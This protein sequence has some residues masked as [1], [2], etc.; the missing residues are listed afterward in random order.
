MPGVVR[1]FLL[2]LDDAKV[3]SR[4]HT[5]AVGLV[6]RKTTKPR[7]TPAWQ[8][9]W[10]LDSAGT[11]FLTPKVEAAYERA[12]VSS[13]DTSDTKWIPKQWTN[14][15]VKFPS[16]AEKAR[17]REEKEVLRWWMVHMMEKHAMFPP[18]RCWAGYHSHDDRCALVSISACPW[19][20]FAF[21]VSPVCGGAL[22]HAKTPE[23]PCPG[24]KK[25]AHGTGAY[26]AIVHHTKGH[27]TRRVDN[28]VD[29]LAR[30]MKYMYVD[31]S[32]IPMIQSGIA[33][34]KRN[35]RKS[36]HPND[37]SQD[38]WLASLDR[39][40]EDNNR[41]IDAH[42]PSAPPMPPTP[43]PPLH[44]TGQAKKQTRR[45]QITHAQLKEKATRLRKELK[46]KLEKGAFKDVAYV[47]YADPDKIKN[48]LK[49]CEYAT[50]DIIQMT[51][52]HTKTDIITL[53][54]LRDGAMPQLN[55]Q[56]Y[57]AS[58]EFDSQKRSKNKPVYIWFDGRNHFESLNHPGIRPTHP[59]QG[60]TLLAVNA[61][62]NRERRRAPFVVTLFFTVVSS[63]PLLA[64]IVVFL[65]G[66]VFVT[67][68]LEQFFG[69]LLRN[70]VQHLVGVELE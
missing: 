12:L 55:V 16:A 3:D 52:V 54:L 70:R 46:T 43:D 69:N 57:W 56:P 6:A 5:P 63:N 31:K 30:T 19:G 32:P 41:A 27:S 18:E 24:V 21:T 45:Q 14:V 36:Y 38:P 28:D 37:L 65:P 39:I 66:S 59:G 7:P 62:Y 13:W 47:S 10:Q 17:V 68:R 42:A 51:A 33:K 15:R 40:L 49:G 60:L 53:G 11:L 35:E 9:P 58:G 23:C 1:A 4:D 44:K 2:A 50:D 48:D 29:R 20:E 26:R 8:R 25:A 61:A 22:W 67:V 34:Q 64:E